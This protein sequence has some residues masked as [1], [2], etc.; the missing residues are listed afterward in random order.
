MKILGISDNRD[1]AVGLKLGGI[2]T[3]VIKNNKEIIE[4]IQQITENKQVGILVIT[5]KIYE[6]AKKEFDNITFNNKFPLIVK[7]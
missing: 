2:D 7:I 4:K 6:M 3:I 1:T 5:N